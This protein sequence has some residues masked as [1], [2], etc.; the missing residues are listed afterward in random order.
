MAKTAPR[1]E[2]AP[3]D[4]LVQ[5]F[6]FL[7]SGR[8]IYVRN[9]ERKLI[10]LGEAKQEGKEG[11][12]SWSY[13]LDVDEIAGSGFKTPAALLKDLSGKVDFAYLD[14]QFTSLPNHSPTDEGI[15]V[16]HAETLEVRYDEVSDDG[17]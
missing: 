12:P 2:G 7:L 11:K 9:A 1:R 10:D 13:L 4:P 6:T 3:A 8:H 15:D 14:S 17:F 16:R 5:T